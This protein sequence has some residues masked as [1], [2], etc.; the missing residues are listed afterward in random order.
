MNI[1]GP[2]GPPPV[3]NTEPLSVTPGSASTASRNVTQTPVA[4]VQVQLSP[5]LFTQGQ[6]LE[7]VISK[8]E[9]DTL[10]LVL[11]N[12]LL[13][14]RGQPLNIQFRTPA[15]P[16][17]EVG[18]QLSLQVAQVKQNL[19]VL[20]L[21]SVSNTPQD[22][23]ANLQQTLANNRPLQSVL[24]HLLAAKQLPPSQVALPTSVR[25]QLDRVW[26]TLPESTQLQRPDH[27]RQALKNTGPFL[28]A[29]LAKMAMGSPERFYPAMDIRAQLLRLAE[30]LRQQIPQPPNTNPTTPPTPTTTAQATLSQAAVTTSTATTSTTTAQTTATPA[31]TQTPVAPKQELNLPNALPRQTVQYEGLKAE[32]I[33]QQLL[34]QTDAGLA[35]IQHQ[36]VQMS[37]ADIRPQWLMEL[38]IKHSDGVD[39]FDIRIQPDAEQQGHSDKDPTHPWTVMLAFNLDGL[40]PV[41]AQISLFNGQISNYWWAEQPETVQLFQQHLSFLEN[42]LQHA[43]VP[44][45]QLVCAC[46][47]PEPKQTQTKVPYSDANLDERA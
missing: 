2:M 21:L 10:L 35:R 40:G 30:A 22:L 4:S 17:A 33:L 26:R 5:N 3:D 34:Q 23:L 41:R 15:F 39:V 13:D 25:E 28:E 9:Q 43:G 37:Q 8:I 32:Q 14:S 12:K 20:Q 24:E 1:Q 31:T 6:I 36:Q 27:L 44:F 46:G 7:A 45:Q 42:R 38:P 18:Q 11:Q 16:G 19:P 29:H 47:I